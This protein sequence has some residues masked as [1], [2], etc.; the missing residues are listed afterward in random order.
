M[1]TDLIG[2]GL[3]T[4]KEASIL[5]K[6]APTNI[7]RWLHGYKG[8]HDQRVEPLWTPQLQGT[9][10][11]GLGFHDLLEIRFVDEFRRYGV[12]LQAIRMASQAAKELYDS[13]YPFTCRKFQTDGKAIF[14]NVYDETG[15]D[16]LLALAKKQYVI[17]EVIKPSLYEGIQFEEDIAVKWYPNSKKKAVVLNPKISF[18]KPIVEN[19]AVPTTTLYESYLVEKDKKFVAR[20]FDVP[21]KSVTDAIEFEEQL[22]A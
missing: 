16:Q 8:A 5:T 18:G 9:D 20:V 7:R 15:E 4:V 22:A 11:E 10:F 19:C 17:N 2:L 12:S 1:N 21:V 14:A 3:Y 13:P 6:V